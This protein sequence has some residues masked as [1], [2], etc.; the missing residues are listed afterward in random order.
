MNY[1]E[2]FKNYC[3]DKIKNLGKATIV[4]DFGDKQNLKVVMLADE[5]REFRNLRVLNDNEN[6][7]LLAIN[8]KNK[9]VIDTCMLDIVAYALRLEF[10]A[11][12][13]SFYNEIIEYWEENNLDE[14]MSEEFEEE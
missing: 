7:N 9:V 5:I 6:G 13:K 4:D 1:K 2:T 11:I 8:E 10:S 14:Y 3:K 12:D